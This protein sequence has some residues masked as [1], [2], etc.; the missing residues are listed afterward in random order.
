MIPRKESKLLKYI[1]LAYS[2]LALAYL[3]FY[4][5]FFEP[6][7]LYGDRASTASNVGR[8]HWGAFILWGVAIAGAL[9]LNIFYAMNKFNIKSRYTKLASLLSL[10]AMA[11]VVL[12]KN[13]KL[14]RFTFTLNFETYTA[15]SFTSEYEDQVLETQKTLIHY[16]LSK[17]SLHSAFAVVFGLLIA[18]AFVSL[19]LHKARENYRFRWFM[20]VLFAWCCVCAFYLKICLG[21]TAELVVITLTLILMLVVFH[22]NILEPKNKPEYE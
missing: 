14:K 9:V 5:R 16:F 18:S 2:I 1:S 22:T 10:P 4:D 6:N 3:W 13:E 19:I 11:G 12:C 15:P 17:K 20:N 8:D 7:P 21:G